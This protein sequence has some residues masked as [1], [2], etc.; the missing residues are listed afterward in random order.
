MK[1]YMAGPLF[2][3]A[4][5]QWNKDLAYYLRSFSYHVFLPQET[6]MNNSKNGFNSKRIFED[7]VGGIKSADVLLAWLEGPDPDSGTCWELGY[8]QGKDKITIAYTTDLRFQ[9]ADF[10]RYDLNLMLTYG[11]DHFLRFAPDIHP[12][13][14][15]YDVSQVIE[16]EKMSVWIGMKNT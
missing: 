2:T 16:K 5:R 9:G 15:A 7:D 11:V 10:T 14:V 8:A 4:E 6:E 12:R 1:I 3:V 13:T